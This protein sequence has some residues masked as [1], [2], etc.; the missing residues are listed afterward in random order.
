MNCGIAGYHPQRENGKG[1]IENEPITE[2]LF[3]TGDCGQYDGGR[4]IR[5]A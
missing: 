2:D 1:D 4:R 5:D 3:K